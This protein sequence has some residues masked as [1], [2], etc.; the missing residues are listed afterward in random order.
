[1]NRKSL[2]ID[3]PGE[4]VRLTGALLLA[5]G[6]ACASPPSAPPKEAL[7]PPPPSAEASTRPSV[8]AFKAPEAFG[9]YSLVD[10]KD[11]GNPSDGIAHAYSSTTGER[12][13]TTFY[14]HDDLGADPEQALDAQLEV[15]QQVLEY[16]RAQ[17]I[18]ASYEIIASGQDLIR[19]SG[20]AVI[21]GRKLGFVYRKGKATFISVLFI[22]AARD[23][24]VKIRG[25]VESGAWEQAQPAF[26]R[27]F[28][29]ALLAL[30]DPL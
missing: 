18:F 9:I 15:F 14:K 10:R 1:M 20:G 25:T 28:M 24:Y 22:Y 23:G 17:G 30:N 3:R 12:W 19:G 27:E 6:L 26:P 11:S 5:L 7:P 13:T 4:I 2:T 8:L 16:Q 29:K 21:H